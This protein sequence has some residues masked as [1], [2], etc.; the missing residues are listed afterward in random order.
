MLLPAASMQAASAHGKLQKNKGTEEERMEEFPGETPP[1][2]P[3]F[4]GI[5]P[6]QHLA[7]ACRSSESW[8]PFFHPGLVQVPARDHRLTQPDPKLLGV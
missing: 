5:N 4:S 7:E 8:G 3:C 1:T 6:L 2:A